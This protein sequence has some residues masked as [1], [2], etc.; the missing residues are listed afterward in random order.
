MKN[1]IFYEKFWEKNK[2]IFHRKK[3][4]RRN[5]IF[6]KKNV[7]FKDFSENEAFLKGI[8]IDENTPKTPHDRYV[9][10]DYPP[11]LLLFSIS[12]G[13]KKAKNA[14]LDRFPRG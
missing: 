5:L 9:L 8:K 3:R 10:L 7:I 13:S 12:W 4:F 6:H 1:F 11:K 2:N 14:Y